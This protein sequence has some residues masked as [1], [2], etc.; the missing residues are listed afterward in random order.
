M[1][2]GPRPHTGDSETHSLAGQAHTQSWSRRVSA[3]GHHGPDTW[4]RFGVCL[5]RLQGTNRP[6]PAKFRLLGTR[7]GAPLCASLGVGRPGRFPD[8]HSAWTPPWSPGRPGLEAPD[9]IRPGS[10][11]LGLRAKEACPSRPSWATAMGVFAFTFITG[12]GETLCVLGEV[13]SLSF[14]YYRL[15]I[16]Y[17]AGLGGF[18]WCGECGLSRVR[19]ASYTNPLICSESP[20]AVRALNCFMLYS[21]KLTSTHTVL[22]QVNP[23]YLQWDFCSVPDSYFSVIKSLYTVV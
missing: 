2:S 19:H 12:Y 10:N 13:Y 18:V 22:S 6:C 15:L 1:P 7:A 20:R 8:P 16:M 23:E 14:P 5:P 9:W 17:A 21:R 3:P 11:F 4:L